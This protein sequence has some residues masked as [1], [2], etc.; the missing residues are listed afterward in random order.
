MPTNVMCAQAV[1]N[2]SACE[3]KAVAVT[4]FQFA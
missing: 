4:Y 3:M 1:L 2:Y